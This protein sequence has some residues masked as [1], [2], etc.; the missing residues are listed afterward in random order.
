MKIYLIA[1]CWSRIE[2]RGKFTKLK[3]GVLLPLGPAKES[4]SVSREIFI[5]DRQKLSQLAKMRHAKNS[6]IF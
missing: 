3:A 5:L 1:L 4:Q 2:A 6:N